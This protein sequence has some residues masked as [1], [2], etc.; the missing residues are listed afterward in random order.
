MGKIIHRELCKGWKFNHTPN[1]YIHKPESV[2]ENDTHELRE[3]FEIQ[4]NQLIPTRKPDLWIIKRKMKKLIC[5]PKVFAFLSDYQLKINDS[6]KINKYLNIVR[7]IKSYI[8]KDDCDASCNLS[9]LY[10]PQNAP[11]K[12][13]GTGNQRKNRDKADYTIN[14]FSQKFDEST[15]NLRRLAIT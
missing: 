9:T 7:E 8:S 1:W 12:A 5:C 4:R 13:G 14:E 6:E 3:S 11:K 2:L 10:D 15:G